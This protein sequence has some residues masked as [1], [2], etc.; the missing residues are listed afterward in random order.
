MHAGRVYGCSLLVFHLKI[1]VKLDD[2]QVL[3][4]FKD[5]ETRTLAQESAWLGG[6][7]LALQMATWQL[8]S[9]QDAV[10]KYGPNVASAPR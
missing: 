9:I 2:Q 3:Y 4:W 8:K 10:A 1:N 6:A 5:V 7:E